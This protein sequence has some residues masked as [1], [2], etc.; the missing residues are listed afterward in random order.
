VGG[1]PVAIRCI[2]EILARDP[3]VPIVLYAEEPGDA[4]NRMDLP[5]VLAGERSMEGLWNGLE[6]ERYPT[7]TVKSGVTVTAVDRIGMTV[8]DNRGGRQRYSH[9]VLVTGTEPVP[10]AIKGLDVPGVY[11]FRT[12]DDLEKVL[13]LPLE[14]TLAV[15][16]GSGVMGLEIAHALIARKATVTLVG[17]SGALERQFDSDGC[18]FVVQYLLE[19]G[20]TI[21]QGRA[22]EILTETS[23][24]GGM[25]RVCG[26]RLIGDRVVR[27]DLVILATGAQPRVDLA[28]AAGLEVG[29]GIKIDDYGHT[30]DHFIY[31]AGDCA[32]HQGRVYGRVHPG[33][34]QAAV[35]AERLLSEGKSKR[36]RRYEGSVVACQVKG[37]DLPVLSM[38]HQNQVLNELEKLEYR[39]PEQKIL[40]KLLLKDGTLSGVIA[41]GEWEGL[42]RVQEDIRRARRLRPAERRRFLK[43][44][45]PYKENEESDEIGRWPES[46]VVCNCRGIAKGQIRQIVEAGHCSTDQICQA[47]G[48][49]GGCGGCRPLVAELARHLGHVGADPQATTAGQGTLSLVFVALACLLAIGAAIGSHPLAGPASALL[50]WSWPWSSAPFSPPWARL[51]TDLLYQ[52]AS[53]YTLVG[54]LALG[55]I[56]TLRK[57][58][59]PFQFL[60]SVFWRNVHLYL[61]LLAVALL[62]LHTGLRFGWGLSLALSASFLL[63]VAAGALLSLAVAWEGGG[64]VP[65]I[66]PWKAALIYVHVL[67]CWILPCL[68]AFHILAVYYF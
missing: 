13:K 27:A 15:I 12:R 8:D 28:L 64:L 45:S 30:S 66:R 26:V 4:Y 7:L 50:P 17:G 44:G 49:G 18:A 58:W 51:W 54:L 11:T 65:W 39:A 29:R 60:S 52:Q 3:T 20:I 16:V 5:L 1:G 67:M 24:E 31:A 46:A 43:T 9:L 48:A 53:G 62:A 56:Y 38:L 6:A 10:C 23:A 14:G 61:G 22:Q 34:E 42:W 21:L 32:E 63:T 55:L 2:K 25:G 36:S 47:T 68:I 40:R 41:V 35:I 37:L 33:Y 59:R 19:I 57:R